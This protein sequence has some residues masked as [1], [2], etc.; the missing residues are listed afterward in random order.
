MLRS[1]L[2]APGDSEKK[3][4]KAS[5]IRADCVILD[6]E[7]SVAESRKPIAREMVRDFL[8][9]K[10]NSNVAFYVRVNPLDSGLILNDLATVIPAKPDGIVFPKSNGVDDVITV[11]NYMDILEVEHGIERGSISMLPLI[12]ETA[13]A[14]FTMG[15]YVKS[16]ERVSSLTWGAEDLGAAVGASANTLPNKDWTAPYQMTRA[17]CL[18]AAHAARV[19]AIDTV[20]ADFKDLSQL[21]KVCDDARRDGFTGKICIHPAQVDVIN[22]AFSPSDEEL[23]HA[24][25]VVQAF[26]SNPDAGTLQIN[27]K[28]ID[29]PHLVLAERVIGLAKQ[30]KAREI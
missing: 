16:P 5:G 11:S 30:I 9:S 24:Q 23:S 17:L 1:L 4:L 22:G 13:V 8:N 20:M 29:K 21:K 15:E 19:Q 25:A 28:M 27:G 18:F 3:M 2:F 10:D 14:I 26:E 12:S 6:L 7:D